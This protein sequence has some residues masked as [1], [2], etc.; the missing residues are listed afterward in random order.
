MPDIPGFVNIFS[1]LRE[2]VIDIFAAPVPSRCF[3][4]F[5]P[6]LFEKL[7][8]GIPLDDFL[9]GTSLLPNL[10]ANDPPFLKALG[11]HAPKLFLTTNVRLV[12]DLKNAVELVKTASK[13]DT[14]PI[15]LDE[16]LAEGSA[17]SFADSPLHLPVMSAFAV[18]PRIHWKRQPT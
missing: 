15:L 18:L 16:T 5:L 1:L 3:S 13:L 2:G 9:I 12:N 14:V 17:V 6:V 4:V 7:R 8:I 10:F 11:C